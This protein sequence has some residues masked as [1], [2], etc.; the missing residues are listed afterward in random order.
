MTAVSTDDFLD[1]FAAKLVS[2][3]IR[4]INLNDTRS[5]H[6]LTNVY[7]FI[8]DRLDQLEASDSASEDWIDSL[9]EIRN[10]FI[11]SP[12]GAFDELE[13]LLRAKQANLVSQPN[14]YYEALALRTPA[15]AAQITL[16]HAV[17]E[18]TELLDQ[19]VAKIA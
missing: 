19:I 14:P 6:S 8:N 3:G 15:A 11:P 9:I 12:I 10:I 2:R 7:E 5:R 17:P 16:E 13:A 18:L 4:E 1:T